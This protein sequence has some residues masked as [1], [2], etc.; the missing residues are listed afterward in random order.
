MPSL[1]N[2]STGA[3]ET[4]SE[5]YQREYLEMQQCGIIQEKPAGASNKYSMELTEKYFEFYKGE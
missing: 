2:E 4:L 1:Y 3:I 5:R